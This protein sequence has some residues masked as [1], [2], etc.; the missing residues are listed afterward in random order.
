MIIVHC[1]ACK[2]E[3][4]VDLYDEKIYGG[5]EKTHL[6]PLFLPILKVCE[7][8]EKYAIDTDCND[9]YDSVLIVDFY[10]FNKG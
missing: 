9:A 6:V 1:P 8:G 7:C 4:E 10:E 3:Y 2:S 5:L